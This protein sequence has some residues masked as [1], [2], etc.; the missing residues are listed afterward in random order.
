MAMKPDPLNSGQPQVVRYRRVK[1][2]APPH[3]Y[4]R[5]AENLPPKRSKIGDRGRLKA[6][7]GFVLKFVIM[8]E[9]LRPQDSNKQ[10]YFCLQRLRFDHGS[11]EYRLGYYIIG[12]KGARKDKW[13]WGQFCPLLPQEDLEWLVSEARRRKWLGLC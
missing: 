10:K 8:D 5:I 9:I 6:P 7:D 12:K 3:R 13:V 2:Q 4:R 1:P 11:E